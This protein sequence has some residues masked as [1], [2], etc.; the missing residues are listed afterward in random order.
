M[1]P[2]PRF[3]KEMIL[4]AAFHLVKEQ[5]IDCL[6]ARNIA[7]ILR[8]S[9]QPIFGHYESMAK[10]K[11]ELFILVNGYH[12]HYFDQMAAD[13]HSI[14]NGAI[15]YVNFAILE[16]NLFRML[17]MSNGYQGMKINEIVETATKESLAEHDARAAGLNSPETM[18]LLTDMW[19]YAHGIASMIVTNQLS[20]PQ[21]EIEHMIKSMYQLL[22]AGR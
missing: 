19:L 12:K 4:E 6:N 21:D 11:D 16:P 10:L 17:Y 18:R 1:P 2:R 7:K 15:L 14:M 9:I 22:T 20:V 13:E 3:S 5:G 8:S